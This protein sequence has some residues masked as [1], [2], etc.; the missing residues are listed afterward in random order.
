MPGIYGRGKKRHV[1]VNYPHFQ[2]VELK[3]QNVQELSNQSQHRMMS[4]GWCL[5]RNLWNASHFVTS[6]NREHSCAPLGLK[7]CIEGLLSPPRDPG[8]G[9]PQGATGAARPPPDFEN[10]VL[11]A[12]SFSAANSGAP[13]VSGALSHCN[14]QR[15]CQAENFCHLSLYNKTLWNSLVYCITILV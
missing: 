11:S 10:K 1:L 2:R 7:G 5:S 3:N 9:S 8:S 14:D 15:A 13:L 4:Q 6:G 12:D